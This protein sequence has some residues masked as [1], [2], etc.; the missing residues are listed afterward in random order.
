VTDPRDARI[1]VLEEAARRLMWCLDEDDDPD[2]SMRGRK[3]GE[4]KTDM[5]RALHPEAPAEG[6]QDE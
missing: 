1:A 6:V 5:R 4:A 3:L 2:A